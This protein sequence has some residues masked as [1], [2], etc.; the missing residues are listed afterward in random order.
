MRRTSFRY[1]ALYA[2]GLATMWTAPPLSAADNYPPPGE[3]P[4]PRFTGQAPPDIYALS[5]PLPANAETVAAGQRL[6]RSRPG[7]VGC[8]TCH[9]EKGDGKGVLAQQFSP[10]P[11]NFACA[12]TVKGIPDGQLFWIVRNGSPGTAM[13]PASAFGKFS[14]DNV[15]QL[16][17]YLRTF[18]R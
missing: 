14:D 15:W 4:Q 13:S 2:L 16:V 11:R 12:Q 18:Q 5:N 10:P 8:V 6:Y 7:Q 1:A 3:C 9:G 17:A